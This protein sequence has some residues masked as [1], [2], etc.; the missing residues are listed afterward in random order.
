MKL[1]TSLYFMKNISVYGFKKKFKYL[2]NMCI[3]LSGLLLNCY[4]GNLEI[5]ISE[6]EYN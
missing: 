1:Y 6:V 5:T 3:N 2:R 4:F